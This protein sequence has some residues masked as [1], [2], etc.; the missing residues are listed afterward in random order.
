MQITINIADK[1]IKS[2][3]NELLDNEIFEQYDT[4]LI[5]EARFKRSVTA[6]DIFECAQ[7]QERLT[8]AL[9][10]VAEDAV[11]DSLHETVCYDVEVVQVP[12]IIKIL[13]KM[14]ADFREKQAANREAEEVKRMVKTLE[15]AGFK[16][17]KA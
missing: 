16:N 7:F 14:L 3:I 6:K 9:R 8:K 1:Q 10:T 17:D 5:K 11:L 12:G 4:A 15:K 2:A 13:D